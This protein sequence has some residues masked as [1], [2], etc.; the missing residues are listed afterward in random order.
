MLFL[1]RTGRRAL[2]GAACAI[3]AL[4]LGPNALSGK[5][6]SSSPYDAA[7]SGPTT[8][9]PGAGTDCSYRVPASGEHGDDG[10]VIHQM[11]ADH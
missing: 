8:V 6:F 7:W 5:D 3:A 1:R 2:P 11:S 9:H 4:L 10:V